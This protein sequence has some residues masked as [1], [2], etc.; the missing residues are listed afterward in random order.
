MFTIATHSIP[1]PPDATSADEWDMIFD[2]EI[3]HRA[4]AGTQRIGAV[5]RGYQN[6]DGS[7]RQRWIETDEEELDAT[8]ARARGRALIAAA[9]EL[10][11]LSDYADT[12]AS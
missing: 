9:D 2:T 1:L 8:D 12:I 3:L 7:I 5:I 11:A 4:F 10:D 6:P